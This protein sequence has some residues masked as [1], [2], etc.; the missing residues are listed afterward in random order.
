MTMFCDN[1][2]KK[3]EPGAKAC[4]FCGAAAGRKTAF[5]QP[6]P[7]AWDTPAYTGGP[8]VPKSKGRLLMGAGA[9]VLLLC[10]AAALAFGL[11]S[12]NPK[13]NVG[14]A[15][16]K[17]AEAYSGVLETVPLFSFLDTAADQNV[18]QTLFLE[19]WD[20][21][22]DFKT[23]SFNPDLLQWLGLRISSDFSQE[24]R[25]LN[26]SAA[27]CYD[28]EEIL[29]LQ[30]GLEDDLGELY[31]PELME[32]RSLVFSTETLGA[33]LSSLGAGNLGD[34]R[35][36]LFDLL[37]A[38]QP[39]EPDSAAVIALVNEID[40]KKTGKSTVT[41]N[42]KG[43]KC[44]GYRAVIP[45]DALETYLDVLE[46]A[47]EAQNRR[48]REAVMDILRSADLAE[49]HLS[50]LEQELLNSLDSASRI[51]ALKDA[52]QDTG[53]V[54][55]DIFLHEGYVAAVKW[56]GP[57]GSFSLYLGGGEA[58]PDDLGL[59]IQMDGAALLL[60]SSG[61]HTGKDEAFTDVTSLR[62]Q[63]NGVTVS[64]FVS[65]L[66]YR[67]DRKKNFT[68]SLQSGP[69]TLA[70]D[71]RALPGLDF[72][73]LELDDVTLSAYNEPIISLEAAYS[74]GPYQGGSR[75]A[76]EKLI[77]SE[78]EPLDLYMFLLQI[79]KNFSSWRYQTGARFPVLAPFFRS[80]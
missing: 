34:L 6:T 66:A 78:A 79:N 42:G 77:L 24:D 21:S 57:E 70:A 64:S 61:N 16:A 18:S 31:C 80:L 75:G 7:A 33:D 8:E 22:D 71:G 52:L 69:I 65:D 11:L 62:L 39:V 29:R 26:L 73:E 36:N 47:C 48:G 44:Q 45:Q 9:A 23:A 28:S 63:T 40:V 49:N 54:E 20:I 67:P 15:I 10:C 60:S 58:Y 27:A 25:L 13:A 51:R 35:F 74:V 46:E 37:E 4:P 3:L 30:L 5:D 2:G 53:D 19:I 12:G 38:F 43:L 41:V 68:W 55:V 14:Q 76:E 72:L 56:E 50:A 59:E 17:S 1:C 32:N